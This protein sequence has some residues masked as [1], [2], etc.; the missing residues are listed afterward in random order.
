MPLHSKGV[1]TGRDAFVIDFDEG[2]LLTRMSEFADPAEDDE[3]LI[4]RYHLNPSAWWDVAKARKSMPP[5]KSFGAYVRSILYRP[6]DYRYGFYHPSVFMS[7]RRPVMKH[8]DQGGNL[9]LVTSRMTK[10]ESFRHVLVTRGIAE[11]ILLS[12]KTSNNAIVFPLYLHGDDGT[13]GELLRVEPNFSRDFL[14]A[15]ERTTGLDVVVGTEKLPRALGAEELLEYIVAILHSPTYR[16]RYG[17]ALARDFPRVPLTD[18]IELLSSLASLGSELIDVYT[19]ESKVLEKSAVEVVGKEHQVENVTWQDDFVWLNKAQTVGFHGVNRA[20]WDFQIGG[21]QVCEKW[22]KDRKGRTLSND[23]IGHYQKI[24]ASLAEIIRLMKEI[25]EV[26]EQHGGWPGAFATTDRAAGQTAETDSSAE[27]IAIPTSRRTAVPSRSGPEPVTTLLE[28]AEPPA[29]VYQAQ[30]PRADEI[31]REDLICQIRQLFSSGGRS[32]ET[33]IKEVATQLGYERVGPRIWEQIDNA[34]RTAARRGIVCSYGDEIRIDSRTIED[35]RRDSLKN[36][37]L[38]SLQG[39][40]WTE[41]ADAIKNFARWL[42][43]RR[44]GPAIDETGRSLIN[45]LI[46]EDRLEADGTKIRRMG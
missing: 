26:I 42:G 13:H 37:F 6:F 3:T 9:L 1:V 19:F 39:R 20:T 4:E 28:A 27:I 17:V 29:A 32:R 16:K 33:A 38:A 30:L 12:S 44:T 35:Y 40:A 31:D 24:V 34:I 18:K 10:G 14:G 41:R 45:G 43:F 22:L 25:D 2:E 21:Y 7:P 36:Q 5:I 11:A 15:V 46:R 8:M 23:D